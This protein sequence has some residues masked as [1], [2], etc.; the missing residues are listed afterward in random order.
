MPAHSLQPRAEGS[1]QLYCSDNKPRML[2]LYCLDF[3]TTPEL[4][5]CQQRHQC[6]K[7]FGLQNLSQSPEA[8]RKQLTEDSFP[9]YK[10]E[11]IDVIAM[12]ITPPEWGIYALLATQLQIP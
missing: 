9:R 2:T 10:V 3:K 5:C 8:R 7:S 12:Y 6:Q 1:H 4:K 11:V